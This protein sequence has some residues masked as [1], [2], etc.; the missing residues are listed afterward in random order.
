MTQQNTEQVFSRQGQSDWMR[1]L[2]RVARAQAI[3]WHRLPL[4]ERLALLAEVDRETE[5]LKRLKA[6]GM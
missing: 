6:G 3:A 5:A 1:S 4:S 2:Q